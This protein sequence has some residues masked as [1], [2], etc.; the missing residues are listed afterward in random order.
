MNQSS[1]FGSEFEGEF[2]SDEQLDLQIDRLVDGEL[3]GK[4]LVALLAA[5]DGTDG[6]WKQCA[7]RFIEQQQLTAEFQDLEAECVGAE[8]NAAPSCHHPDMAAAAFNTSWRE[9][10]Y[11]PLVLIVLLFIAALAPWVWPYVGQTKRENDNR[12][13]RIVE[14]GDTVQQGDTVS[15]SI[16]YVS[17]SSQTVQ[18]P[19]YPLTEQTATW[20]H[21]EAK[22]LPR[23]VEL[24]LLQHG[25]ELRRTRSIAPITLEDGSNV[26]IPMEEVEILPVI[27]Q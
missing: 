16:R 4:Q 18:V 7:I 1:P 5:L 3:A 22:T 8:V 11:G 14:E 25:K 23:E 12:M 20:L 13:P 6:G 26:Y 15:P 10:Q 19:A 27:W 9:G 24:L 17:A 2:E 21:A